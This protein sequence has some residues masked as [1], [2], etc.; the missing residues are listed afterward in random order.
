MVGAGG[1]PL[2]PTAR[3][4]GGGGRTSPCER[5]D[6][7]AMSWKGWLGV[8]VGFTLLGALVFKGPSR[9][10]D[11]R[12]TLAAPADGIRLDF[13]PEAVHRRAS[14]YERRKAACTDWKEVPANTLKDFCVMLYPTKEDAYEASLAKINNC[15]PDGYLKQNSIDTDYLKLY[16]CEEDPS[17][18]ETVGGAWT[19]Q[20]MGPFRTTGGYDWNEI[21]WDNV[22]DFKKKNEKGPFSVT[23]HF[24]GVSHSDGRIAANPPL[25]LHHIHVETDFLPIPSVYEKHGDSACA[26]E[27]GGVGCLVEDLPEPYGQ[28]ISSETLTFRCVINDVRPKTEEVLEWYAE[29]SFRTTYA[30]TASVARVSFSTYA[31]A[32]S[33]AMS[34]KLPVERSV[35][36]SSLKTIHDSWMF[37][38]GV[39]FHATLVEEMWVLLGDANMLGLDIGLFQHDSK[40][41]WDSFVPSKYGLEMDAVKELLTDRY[42][43][44]KKLGRLPGGGVF[45]KLKANFA[46]EY[47]KPWDRQ[48]EN[49]SCLREK[50][51]RHYKKGESLTIVLFSNAD[52]HAWEHATGPATDRARK[53]RPQ[54]DVLRMLET[55]PGTT[56]GAASYDCWPG[57]AGTPDCLHP[58]EYLLD[59]PCKE[60]PNWMSDDNVVGC[61]PPIGPVF[62]LMRRFGIFPNEKLA[63]SR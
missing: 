60:D 48:P 16:T 45:C 2:L 62:R 19:F 53:L 10:N 61:P 7:R 51:A 52:K 32:N 49:N 35:M 5:L 57:A 41:P 28:H 63:V 59:R 50:F 12:N 46:Y 27:L 36:W 42:E 18:A 4:P 17:L 23:G 43:L 38:Y 31:D 9:L 56:R 15:G 21:Y 33:L 40:H 55:F 3:L 58:V 1:K 47:D 37:P 30:K 25:H 26:E 39:H 14:E 11:P 20:R 54:H 34:Y 24:V 44:N 22:G 6:V 8:L 29:A 13:E